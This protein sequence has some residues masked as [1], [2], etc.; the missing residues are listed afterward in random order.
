MATEVE[1]SPLS[2]VAQIRN[3]KKHLR[4]Q[5]RENASLKQQIKDLQ[6]TIRRIE[7]QIQYAS[8]NQQEEDPIVYIQKIAWGER[9]MIQYE[10]EHASYWGE[11]CM[12]RHQHEHT[13]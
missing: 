10:R 1:K 11:K 6:D 8:G 13:S 2:P 5:V 4:N 9:C 3:L 12:T 7:I